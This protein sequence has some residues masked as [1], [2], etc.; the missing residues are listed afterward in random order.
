MQREEAAAVRTASGLAQ[1]ARSSWVNPAVERRL[2]AGAG[3][4]AAA[5]SGRGDAWD[6]GPSA[7]SGSA[8]A[9]AGGS[10]S[11]LTKHVEARERMGWMLSGSGG[12]AAAPGASASARASVAVPSAASEAA[13]DGSELEYEDRGDNKEAAVQQSA[14]VAAATDTA[15]ILA[16]ARAGPPV[17]ANDS[18]SSAL[19]GTQ[20]SASDADP[21]AAA[22]APA[23]VSSWRQRLLDRRGGALAASA[24]S[25]GTGAGAASS[26][27]ATPTVTGSAAAAAETPLHAGVGAGDAST[28]GSA[29]G[30]AEP[31]A[32]AD[33]FRALLRGERAAPPAPTAVSAAAAA[34]VA[35]SASAA[36]AAASSGS[37]IAAAPA[38]PPAPAAPAP[39]LNKL[40]AALLRAQMLGDAAK[41][42]SLQAQLDAA[43]AAAAS[44]A[45]AAQTDAA[46]SAQPASKRRR[47]EGVEDREAD[48]A[49]E[50]AAIAAA[51]GAGAG[52]SA[53]GRGSHSVLDA[54]GRPVDVAV[55]QP[56][57]AAGRPIRSLLSGHTPAP[58]R[59]DMKPAA[60]KWHGRKN[61]NVPMYQPAGAGAGAAAAGD[62]TGAAGAG[63]AAGQLPGRAPPAARVGY[64]P[65]DIEDAS[66][67]GLSV[68]ELLRRERES[69]RGGP[70]SDAALAA[71][72]A[73]FGRF[74]EGMLAGM[75]RSGADEEGAG[76][77]DD[78]ARIAAGANE[79]HRLTAQERQRRDMQRAVAAHQ[80]AE[81]AVSSCWF[82]L[83]N[84]RMK[85]HCIVSLGDHCMLMLP[86]DGPA[87][88]GHMVLAPLAHV[89]SVREADEATYAELNTAKARLHAMYSAAGQDVLFLE[90]VLPSAMSG[91]GPAAGGGG[92]MPRRHTRIDVIPMDKEAALDAPLYF[93]KAMQDADQWATHRPVIDTAGKGLRGSIPPGFPYFWVSWRGG[94][95]VHVIEE[96]DASFPSDFGLSVCAGMMGV[97]SM[98][99]FRSML[100]SSS[101]GSA[102]RGGRGGGGRGGGG[103]SGGSAGRGGGSSGGG[104]SMRGGAGPLSFEAEKS[105]VLSFLKQWERFDWTAELDGG[106]QE[107]REA[108]P[109]QRTARAGA[110]AG[111]TGSAGAVPQPPRAAAVLPPGVL[112]A[113]AAGSGGAAARVRSVAAAS[114]HSG[115]SARF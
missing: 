4:G 29:G 41:V 70:S 5:H 110:S 68:Q 17:A 35:S 37:S 16:A 64:L 84:P 40:A 63:G 114:E 20:L 108:G 22:P 69:G 78:L 7:A 77:E 42:A 24:A 12:S 59:A 103:R 100:S 58:E 34:P 51:E 85:K 91:G 21:A 19:P 82:C 109:P 71:G 57:D 99:E 33:R 49:T 26:D 46:A 54:S 53:A 45:V 47:V 31:D 6:E 13:V 39:D 89:A 72:I 32:A 95:Y 80:A 15:A 92:G 98:G 76:D 104:G 60:S 23:P 10:A 66:G 101:S 11:G 61:P 73:R 44:S 79:E 50:A 62:A 86:P 107:G 97:D 52:A 75:T 55:I 18:S 43:K 106:A 36:A 8:G 38:A 88:P 112:G 67:A 48:R 14:A 83:D 93:K 87:L 28:G 111:T 113:D 105:A 56:F 27:G 90:T 81:R 96:E 30:G 2:G 102:G 74:R 94:G 1:G 65:E 115:A 9:R 3:S 25:T